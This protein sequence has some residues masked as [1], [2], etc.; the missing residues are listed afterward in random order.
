M[1]VEVYQNESEIKRILLAW[2]DG[3]KVDFRSNRSK[4]WTRLDS[5]EDG[6][7]ISVGDGFEYR[8]APRT[9]MIGDMEVP[10]PETEAPPSNTVYWIPNI[11][12][13]GKAIRYKWDSDGVDRT[14]LRHGWLHLTEEAAFQHAKALIKI[15]G[16]EYESNT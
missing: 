10:A 5:F 3:A 8:L 6:G 4:G 14:Y 12:L 1:I 7:G 2:L 11:D 9:I 15:S 16:G 13:R